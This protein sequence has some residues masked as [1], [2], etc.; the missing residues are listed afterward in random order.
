MKI[1]TGE[2][3]WYLSQRISELKEMGHFY[4]DFFYIIHMTPN[5]KIKN[6]PV[7][8]PVS[9]LPTVPSDCLLFS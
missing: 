9:P 5:L 2:L 1:L 6:I 4:Y 3:N 8:C 7:L